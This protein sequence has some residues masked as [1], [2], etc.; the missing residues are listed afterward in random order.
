MNKWLINQDFFY[1]EPLKV[2]GKLDPQKQQE[3]IEEYNK[4]KANLKD[5]EEIYFIDAVHPD[6]QSQAACGWIKSE[7]KTLPTTNKQFRLHFIGAINLESMSVFSRE[8]TTVNA[9]NMIEYLNILENSSSAKKIHVI[10]DNGRANKNKA[11]EEY[12][13]RSKIGIHYLPPYSPN[14]NPVERLWKLMRGRKTYNKCYK[15][16]AEFSRAIRE[17]FFEEIPKMGKSLKTRINDNFQRIELNP[18]QLF[19]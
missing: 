18:I 14:L 13:R 8:Y 6:F 7:T 16:F 3:F 1:K 9:E 12:L 10:S 19:N 17:F 2:P 5:D 4:L 15:N 11:L